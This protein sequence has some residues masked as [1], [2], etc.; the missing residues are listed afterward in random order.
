[1]ETGFIASEGELQCGCPHTCIIFEIILW[2]NQSRTISVFL[3]INARSSKNCK[4]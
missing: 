1:V 3:R 4:M 2:L